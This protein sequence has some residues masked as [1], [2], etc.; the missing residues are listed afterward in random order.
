MDATPSRPAST[1]EALTGLAL[2]AVILVP[3]TVALSTVRQIRPMVPVTPQPSSYGYTWS[4][5]L[6]VVPVVTLGIWFHRHPKYRQDRKSFWISAAILFT[7][8]LC[9]DFFF[10][11]RFFTYENHGATLGIPFPVIGSLTLLVVLAV[12]GIAYK[13]LG[14]HPYNDGMP[15]YYLFL[16]AIGLGPSL[17]FFPVVKDAISWRALSFTVVL[18]VLVSL[19][20][21][22]VLAVPTNG[23]DSRTRIC[24]ASRSTRSPACRSR[25][26]SCGSPSP[27][28]G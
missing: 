16:L 6:F 17:L 8:G 19:L 26:R 15:W 11:I 21:E 1:S 23:E 24:S 4:L 5:L 2:L 13:K 18:M 3:A 22:G 7:F 14:P 12:A 10:G 28:R 25:S 20:W 27:T 9:L